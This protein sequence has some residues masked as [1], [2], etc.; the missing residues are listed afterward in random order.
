[1]MLKFTKMHGLGNDFAVIDTIS[2]KVEL[3][4][5]NIKQLAD[6]HSGIGFDQLLLI[7]PASCNEADFDYQVF[8]A[9]ASEAEQC[10]NGVRCVARYLIENKITDKNKIKL[11]SKAGIMSV[12]VT[13]F[14]E[15][16]VNMGEPI[17]EPSKIP[18]NR[19]KQAKSYIMHLFETEQ[20]V[21]AV[22]MGNPHVIVSVDDVKTA[23]IEDLG[24][25]LTVHQD[26]PEG[27][28]VGFM[29]I[30]DRA[31]IKLCVYERGAG[32]TLACGTG[33]CAAVVAGVVNGLLDESVEVELPG[34]VL[35]ISWPGLSNPVMMTGPAVNVY[36]GYTKL[37]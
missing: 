24:S 3:S 32:V 37:L 4:S 21:M 15:I 20:R 16:S 27:V 28:N 6:R 18:F 2:Q 30:Q 9:D 12:N 10:G 7:K 11:N 35:Q 22:S 34:G 31:R 5:E 13:N 23:P 8:N 17:L 36:D 1:M 29:Q 33:A 19:S 26:F 25:R 14:D